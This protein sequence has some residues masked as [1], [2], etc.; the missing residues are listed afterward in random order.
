MDSAAREFRRATDRRFIVNALVVA[1]LTFFSGFFS[2]LPLLAQPI[3][4]PAQA[5]GP[6]N[7]GI[8]MA[9]SA[10][11]TGRT[12]WH[13][14]DFDLAFRNVG[15]RDVILNLGFMLSN[16]K[17]QHPAAVQL[18][19]RD[20]KGVAREFSYTSGL[21]AIGG[22]MDDLP[23]ALPS[24]ATYVMRF[25]LE[26][27]CCRAQQVKLKTGRYRL[28][29]RVEGRGARSLNVDTPGIALWNFWKGIVRSNSVEFE[30]S[31]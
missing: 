7:N 27:F 5:C 19:L 10:V 30:V 12:S 16:G 22:R 29:A 8:C 2:Y 14:V 25:N 9:L 26:R 20:S 31:P 18:T 13:D 15:S 21:G 28:T 24:G 23:V 4:N 3:I 1:T 17:V 11:R 6:T